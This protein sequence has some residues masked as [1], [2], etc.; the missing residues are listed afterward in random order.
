MIDPVDDFPQD[1]MSISV[2]FPCLG[3]TV[4]LLYCF[5]FPSLILM[6]CHFRYVLLK[7]VRLFFKSNFLY[8][9]IATSFTSCTVHQIEMTD[10]PL[11][12]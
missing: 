8:A 11:F 12:P 5:P 6:F 1:T 2:D 3:N 9:H 4:F 7:M 10:F